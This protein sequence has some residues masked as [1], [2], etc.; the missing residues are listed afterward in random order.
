MIAF[1]R[2]ICPCTTLDQVGVLESSKSAMYTLAPELSALMTILRSTGPVI[3]TR[4]SC[5]SAG[6]GA[7][8]QSPARIAAVS[9]RK[10]G[11]LPASSLALARRA[12]LEQLPAP[13]IEASGELG[14]E[15]KGLR[16]QDLGVFGR[17]LA[18]QLDAAGK[19]SCRFMVGAPPVGYF[20]L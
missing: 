9:G 8:V 5:R 6:A 11:S 3:S 2:L 17:D 12:S 10:S 15:L 18:G 7:T 1:F 13:G 4:R 19:N 14:D 16:G 20:E